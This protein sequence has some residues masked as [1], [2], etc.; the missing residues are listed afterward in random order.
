MITSADSAVDQLKQLLAAEFGDRLNS[1]WL[2]GSRARGDFGPWSDIDLA[3]ILDGVE[4]WSE[5]SAQRQRVSAGVARIALETET[6]P[7]LRMIPRRVFESDPSG[8]ITA[9]KREGRRL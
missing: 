7:S 9:I 6:V 5:A 1:V 2:F 8:L 4:T 3:V